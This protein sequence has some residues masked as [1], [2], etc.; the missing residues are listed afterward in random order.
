[1]LQDWKPVLW[2]QGTQ[3]KVSRRLGEGKP[4]CLFGPLHPVMIIKYKLWFSRA[5][6]LLFMKP[7]PANTEISVGD[8][9]LEEDNEFSRELG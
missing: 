1:M 3:E 4:S 5:N 7:T 9:R 2:K 8:V 6:V